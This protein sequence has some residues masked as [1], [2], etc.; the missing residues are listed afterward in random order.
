MKNNPKKAAIIG[1][2]FVGAATAFTLMQSKLFSELVLLDANHDKAVG[3]A[4]DIGHGIPFAGEMDIYAGGYDDIA[5]CSMIII[6]AGANQ[7]P[8]ETRLDLVQKNV[9][10]YKDIL[11]EITRRNYEGILL[12]V[13]NPVDILTYVAQKL[14]G[15]PEHRVIGSGTVLDTARLKYALSQQLDVDSRN[16][17]SFIIGEHGDSEIVAWSSTN[18]SGVPL[19]QFLEM[20]GHMHPDMDKQEIA[21]KVKNSA[22]DIIAKKDAT[23]YGI[24]MSVRRICECMIRDEKSILPIST[25]MHGDFGIEDVCLSMPTILSAEGMETHIPIKLSETEQENLKQSADTLK[26]ILAGLN[27]KL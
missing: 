7:K 25:N 15:L 12:V 4:E 17:H 10:I 13:S 14:S 21:E 6:T 3:E 11:S 8:N 27:L 26:H 24:A 19:D 16:I 1:C 2:G 18:I 5:D 23:Y 20:R 22:Y 9:A